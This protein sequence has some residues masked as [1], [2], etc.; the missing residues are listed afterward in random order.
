MNFSC[1][2]P[3]QYGVCGE[4]AEKYVDQGSTHR[5]VCEVHAQVAIRTSGLSCPHINLIDPEKVPKKTPT[6]AEWK[7]LSEKN[8]SAPPP[9]MPSRPPLREAFADLGAALLELAK[10]R[11]EDWRKR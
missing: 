5:P 6:Q 9:A 10:G 11:L 7:L 3:G 4:K 1:D 2:W 8:A